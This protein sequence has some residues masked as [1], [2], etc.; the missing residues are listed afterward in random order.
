MKY[1][2]YPATVDTVQVTGYDINNTSK[3][4]EYAKIVKTQA[5][6]K[7]QTP[8]NVII[9]LEKALKEKENG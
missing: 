7:P 1:T 4:F 9:I 8:T 2:I 6:L 5:I 3:L